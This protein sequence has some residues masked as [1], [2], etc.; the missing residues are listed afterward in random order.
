MAIVQISKIQHRTG[1]N[2]DLPQLD[3][4]ELGY[5][6]DEGRL[7][8]GNDPT[9]PL[10]TIDGKYINEI[11]TTSSPLDFSRIEGSSN[12]TLNIGN[13]FQ[14][15]Q[16]LVI[17]YESSTTSNV[18]KNYDGNLLYGNAK[19]NLG[20]AGN[21]QITGGTN[22]YVLQTDGNGNLNWVNN[23]IVTAPI[24]NVSKANPA[25]VTTQ[26][27]HY[28]G[29]GT[30]VFISNVGGMTQLATGG[31]SGTNMY[32]ARRLTSNTFSLFTNANLTTGVNSTLF[33][34]ATAN[35]GS[36]TAQITPTG[37]AVPS[38][39]NTQI[40]FYD[41]AGAFGGSGNLTF[42]KST[43]ILAV[44]GNVNATN[45][46][47]NFYGN[48]NGAV[49]AITPNTATFTSITVNT[50]ANV[51]ANLNV[52]NIS[53][54][55]NISNANVVSANSVTANTVS[56]NVAMKLAVYANNT[57]R[58]T[59]IPSPAAGM[60]IFNQTGS[61]FQGFNGSSWVDLN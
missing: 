45:V 49:G 60:M 12:I 2:V 28:L 52:G 6:T 51:T 61:K 25:V 19:L 37:N 10:P 3:V 15:G 38:G 26:S 11:L 53:A 29:I 40:Q 22:G 24:A 41:T 58:D 42:N 18:V 39:A 57:A 36:A 54:T 43:N 32:Y 33:F 16:V 35:T 31:V 21:L 23:G 27:E 13:T 17:D 5:A 59:A 34:N 1:A 44:G 14:T 47:S 4:G 46:N 7:Y 48:L 8:I 50:N 56:T 20:P 9:E 30:L 55:G